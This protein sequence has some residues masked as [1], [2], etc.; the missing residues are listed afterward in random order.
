MEVKPPPRFLFTPLLSLRG[1]AR[2]LCEP[3]VRPKQDDAPETVWDFAARRIGREA[4]DLLV[5][6]MVTGVFGGD[7][8]QLSL[9]HCFPAMAAMER[10]YGSL[11]RALL[12]RKRQNRAASPLGPSGVLTSFDEGIG[13]LS[14][15]ASRLL[16]DRIRCRTGAL[17]LAR[18]G[19]AYRVETNAGTTVEAEA[20]L[21]ALPAYAASEVT[22]SLDP[23][24]SRA[25]SAIG[26]ADIAVVCTA[27]RRERVRHDLNGFGF[28]VPRNQNRRVLGCLWTSSIF[29]RQTPEGW[30]LLRTMYGGYTDPAALDLSDTELLEYLEREVH[31]LLGIDTEPEFVRIFRHRRGIPQYLLHHGKY[32]RVVE[33][34]EA[35][36]PGLLF[37][38]NAYR[39]VGLNDCVVS[40]HRAV[41]RLAAYLSPG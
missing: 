3:F 14:E 22:A 15:T 31:P 39:G 9:A 10:E 11:V 23:R 34:A 17:R 13:F 36:F 40:A 8:R 32:L 25:L 7:A 41:Q 24:L 37:A 12:A 26:Y 20:V 21:V 38:G 5:A 6:P 4:A 35:G 29:P 27:Y 33:T 16:T 1:R 2:L 30:V 18:S 28:V 19:A